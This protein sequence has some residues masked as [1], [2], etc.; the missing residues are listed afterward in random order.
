MGDV[1]AD[2]TSA[3]GDVGRGD[4][5][6]AGTVVTGVE[7]GPPHIQNLP[8]PPVEMVS[9]T[10]ERLV[11]LA[12]ARRNRLGDSAWAAISGLGASLPATIH[13]LADAY[14]IDKPVGLSGYRLIE[15]AVTFCFFA[16]TI[17]SIMKGRE[18]SAEQILQEILNPRGAVQPTWRDIREM[19][20]R[21][22]FG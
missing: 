9:V 5:I 19:S 8:A 4:S 15:V 1:G 13:D 6:K 17:A 7:W 20:W 12:N 3:I 14:W 16:F 22:L 21:K 2:L 18:K 11:M 10:R